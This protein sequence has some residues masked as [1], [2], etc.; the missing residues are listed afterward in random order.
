MFNEV[1]NTCFS[2]LIEHWFTFEKI[3]DLTQLMFR[4]LC[5]IVIDLK[6]KKIK[7]QM[8]FKM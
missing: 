4:R 5:K 6:L 8:I 7:T 3:M 2:P 1:V